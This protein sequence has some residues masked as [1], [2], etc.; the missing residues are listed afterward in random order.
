MAMGCLSSN[1]MLPD[2]AARIGR[3]EWLMMESSFLNSRLLESRGPPGI[4]DED[5]VP[6][7]KA[8]RRGLQ[9]IAC[10]MSAWLSSVCD[11]ASNRGPRSRRLSTGSTP[12]LAGTIATWCRL[13]TLRDTERNK[14]WKGSGGKQ[15]KD[16]PEATFLPRN[17]PDISLPL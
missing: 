6:G 7:G 10:A 15:G 12:Q 9:T 13:A 5:Q 11:S 2:E 16:G 3:A 17:R 1:A 14:S 4:G 8:M